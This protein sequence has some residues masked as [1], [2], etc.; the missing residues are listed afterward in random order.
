MPKLNEP[1]RFHNQRHESTLPYPSTPISSE[2]SNF[3]R[4]ARLRPQR[5]RENT[6]SDANNVRGASRCQSQPSPS[7]YPGREV[8]RVRHEL[9]PG[10]KIRHDD[11]LWEIHRIARVV[12]DLCEVLWADSVLSGKDLSHG[13]LHEKEL[14]DYAKR[15]RLQDDGLYKVAWH[16]TWEPVENFRDHLRDMSHDSKF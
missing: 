7:T 8:S 1:R 2:I 10:D 14:R 9:Q 11:E 12:G 16:S 4:Q 6:R 15:V 13:I 3:G 5:S